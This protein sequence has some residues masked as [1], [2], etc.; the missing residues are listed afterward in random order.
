[1][2]CSCWYLVSINLWPSFSFDILVVLVVLESY[3]LFIF[4]YSSRSWW[5][6]WS[7]KSLKIPLS[8]WTPTSPVNS[9]F[10]LSSL[11]PTGPGFSRGLSNPCTPACPGPDNPHTPGYM[12]VDDVQWPL[13]FLRVQQIHF[14]LLFLQAL[15]VQNLLVVHVL[16][17]FHLIQVLQEVLVVHLYQ[18]LHH[19]LRETRNTLM[20]WYILFCCDS[21]E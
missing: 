12:Y 13:S 19:D 16:L 9:A 5:P 21:L 2:S 10:P 20:F 6:C 7:L 14:F 11:N 4:L 18:S 17:S 15:L 8:L 3:L 1:M